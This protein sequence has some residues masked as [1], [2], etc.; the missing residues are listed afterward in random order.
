MPGILFLFRGNKGRGKQK[1]LAHF[2]AVDAT[3]SASKGKK[4]ESESKR[5]KIEGQ[6]NELTLERRKDD[7]GNTC[8]MK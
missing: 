7:D 2:D 4:K 5:T 6:A 1:V 3:A 8:R